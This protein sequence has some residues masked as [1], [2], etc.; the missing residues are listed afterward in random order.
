VYELGFGVGARELALEGLAGL[1]EDVAEEDMSAGGV[2]E[3]DDAGAYAKSAL[4]I[5]R[6]LCLAGFRF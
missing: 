3:A 2:E 6:L 5:F 4:E 1:V